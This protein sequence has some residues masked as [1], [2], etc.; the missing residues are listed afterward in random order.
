V[1]RQM[2]RM[3]QRQGQVGAD[4]EPVAAKREPQKRPAQRTPAQR[5]AP[6][7]FLREVRGELRKVA[8]PSRGEVI[9]YSTVVLVTVIL[10]IFLILAFD[11]AFS[12]SVLFLF[13]S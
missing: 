2:K 10:L 11:Y 6:R 12:K 13:K 7:Q 1:N 3:M 5:T 9:N 8:W 4:G